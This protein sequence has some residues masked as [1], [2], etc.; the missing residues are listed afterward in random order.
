MYTIACGCGGTKLLVP[1]YHLAAKLG[2][3]NGYGRNYFYQCVDAALDRQEAVDDDH[4]A[5]F[6]DAVAGVKVA[7]LVT[8]SIA[9]FL[10]EL[11]QLTQSGGCIFETHFQN[12][13]M[14]KNKA[15]AILGLS[16]LLTAKATAQNPD[17]YYDEVQRTFY[18]GLIAGANFTQLD[19][20]NYAG[21]HKVG[22]NA[23]GIVYT[24]FDEHLAASIE[25]L[26]SQKGASSHKEQQTTAGAYIRSYNVRL[27][28]AEVPLQL[29]YFDRRRSHFGAGVAISR[30][31]SVKEE[32]E[33]NPIPTPVNLADYPFKK[34]DYNFIIGG[35]LHLV[36]GLFLNAR[37]QYSLVP[38][39]KGEG[40]VPP[41]F[42]GRNEQYNN[43]W[44]VRAMY[45]F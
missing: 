32:G 10:K 24:R 29:C 16:M 28:Y 12:K 27:N 40:N 15:L 36:K 22:I 34:M 33:A 9:G 41:Y 37:F 3:V 20:D 17:S 5:F 23:G 25:I 39:R 30:L 8:N 1:F 35:S 7:L 26:Y 38:V 13:R 14:L 31:V 45:L 42:S 44:T 2:F 21:Y 11:L 6:E 19:G 4:T 43:M 18:G